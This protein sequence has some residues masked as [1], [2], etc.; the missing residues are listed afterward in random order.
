MARESSLVGKA[1]RQL[2]PYV[3]DGSIWYIKTNERAMRGIPDMI[4]CVKGEFWAL[5]FKRAAG[6]DPAK[7]QSY[8]LDSIHK[9]GG[10]A[11]LVHPDNWDTVLNLILERVK[12]GR[13][14]FNTNDS[15]EDSHH[16][17]QP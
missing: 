6:I 17:R 15:D 4:L 11:F 2:K 12:H 14:N 10:R 5:E 9:A 7:L 16:T 1:K 8:N 3:V 13:R